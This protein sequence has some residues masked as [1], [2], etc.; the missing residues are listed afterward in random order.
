MLIRTGRIRAVGQVLALRRLA[1]TAVVDRFG[2]LPTAFLGNLSSVYTCR[3]TLERCCMPMSWE[4]P[5]FTE[6]DY[7][8][9]EFT[10]SR[11]RR[12]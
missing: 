6:L 8:A 11:Q 3:G 2:H 7:A 4:P 5:D 10:D 12:F 9:S 1:V